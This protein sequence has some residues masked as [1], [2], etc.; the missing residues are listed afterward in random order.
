ML[1]KKRLK[2]S[3][4]FVLFILKVSEKQLSDL[5]KGNEYCDG[6]WVDLEAEEFEIKM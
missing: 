4:C 5:N 1:F 3:C 6:F 2:L